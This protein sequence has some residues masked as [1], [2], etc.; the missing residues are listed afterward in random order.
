MTSFRTSILLL[1]LTA[2]LSG[3]NA[4]CGS[5]EETPTP[6]LPPTPT[7]T[8]ESNTEAIAAALAVAVEGLYFMSESDYPFTVVSVEGAATE[9]LT[10]DNIK[11]AIA[12]IYVN[13]PDQP[14]LEERYVE[15]RTLD[16]FFDHLVTPEDWWEE[17]NY[18]QAE[19]YV[20]LQSILENDVQDAQYF[21]LG[22][23]VDAYGTVYGAVD[24]YLVGASNDGDLIGVWTISIET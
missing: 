14:P 17:Y 21:R 20:E 16:Q 15:V 8:V 10:A 22:D 24:V 7:P 13:R 2:T 4:Q 12:P 1:T 11:T 18:Q 3:V 23:R 19:Q 5:V 9:P 6:T